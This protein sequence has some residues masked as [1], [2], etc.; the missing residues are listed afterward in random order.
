MLEL[1]VLV[2]EQ[3]AS[4]KTKEIK[5]A[6]RKVIDYTTYYLKN[7]ELELEMILNEIHLDIGKRPAPT[8]LIQNL[9]N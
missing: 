7:E 6:L 8:G 1:K 3:I 2:E 4:S 5:L 9:K